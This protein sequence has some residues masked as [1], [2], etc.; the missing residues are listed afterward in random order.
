MDVFNSGDIVEYASPTGPQRGQVLDVR[1]AG[2]PAGVTITYTIG[3]NGVPDPI[4]VTD[5]T[6]LTKLMD[7]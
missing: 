6:K 5:E 4:Q 3:L 7:R 2:G 1:G